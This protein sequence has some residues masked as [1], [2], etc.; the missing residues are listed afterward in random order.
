MVHKAS[1]YTYMY[2]WNGAR[3]AWHRIK[4]YPILY[5]TVNGGEKRESQFNRLTKYT[6]S[7]CERKFNGIRYDVKFIYMCL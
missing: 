2:E 5:E 7:E 6:E 3:M 1:I 4:L